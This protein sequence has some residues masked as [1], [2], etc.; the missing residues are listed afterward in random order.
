MQ[1]AGYMDKIGLA[2]V[3]WFGGLIVGKM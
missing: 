2:V 3:V 1:L